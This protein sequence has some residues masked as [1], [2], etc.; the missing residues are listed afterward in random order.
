MA[1]TSAFTITEPT[2]GQITLELDWQDAQ[3]LTRILGLTNSGNLQER[4]PALYNFVR[5]MVDRIGRDFESEDY[6]AQT[7]NRQVYVYPVQD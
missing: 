2:D 3:I 5:S 4:S 1:S 6:R 7:S